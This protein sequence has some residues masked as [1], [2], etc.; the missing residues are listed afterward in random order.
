MDREAAES[1]FQGL[2]VVQSGHAGVDE[3]PLPIDL[4]QDPR[5]HAAVHVA[6]G[7]DPIQGSQ[8]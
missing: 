4:G 6:C 2:A 1:S 7:H 3:C 5:Q 8:A